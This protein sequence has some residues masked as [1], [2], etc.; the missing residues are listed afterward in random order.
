MVM[1]KNTLV[2][3]FVV[4]ILLAIGAGYFIGHHKNSGSSNQ[5]SSTATSGQTVDL[6]GQQLTTVPQSVLNQ[7]DIRN[8][9]LSNN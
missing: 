9:N 4:V 5:N 8:L 3:S 6:S 7:T 2:V 1:T